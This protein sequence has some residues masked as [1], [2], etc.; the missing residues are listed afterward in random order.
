MGVLISSRPAAGVGGGGGGGTS[1]IT[2]I[3]QG[4]NNYT[5]SGGFADIDA[6]HLIATFTL[7]ETRTVLILFNFTG[8]LSTGRGAYDF[9]ID[10]V[11]AGDATNGLIGVEGPLLARFPVNMM[12]AVVLAKG[13]HTIKPQ[14]GIVSGGGNISCLG[15]DSGGFGDG[16]P[17]LFVLACNP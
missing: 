4:N 3:A 7:L 5:H 2:V 16:K 12:H 17:L 13:N 10:G 11:R 8:E 1:D 6:V 15:A 9:L 14:Y